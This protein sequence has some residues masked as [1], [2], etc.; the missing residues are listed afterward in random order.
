[1]QHF[2]FTSKLDW[3]SYIFSDTKTVCKETGAVTC[4]TKFNSSEVAPF[5]YHTALYGIMS[6]LVLQ[7]VTW[8]CWINYRN[9]YLGL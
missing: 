2:S 6:G 1:M 7:T 3:G 8:I 4:F 5:L 9:G